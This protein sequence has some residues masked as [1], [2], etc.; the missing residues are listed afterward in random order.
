MLGEQA[1]RVLDAFAAAGGHVIEFADGIDLPAR[2]AGLIAP[3]LRLDPPHPD[4][5][6]IHYRKDGIDFYLLV[7]EGGEN[8]CRRGVAAR[9][10]AGGVLG[11]A[12]RLPPA[13]ARQ[14][15]RHR[16]GRRAAP[17]APR[18]RGAGG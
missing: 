8:D 16:S 15:R 7:N 17:A 12:G 4:L 2:L 11:C 5:R 1:Q 10:R 6:F 13:G 9:C 18:E 14:D 3:D